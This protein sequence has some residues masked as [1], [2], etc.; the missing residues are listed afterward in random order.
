[1]YARGRVS[2]LVLCIVAG[3]GGRVGPAGYRAQGL[4]DGADHERFLRDRLTAL[5]HICYLYC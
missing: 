4:R 1:M 3:V 2:L 5:S